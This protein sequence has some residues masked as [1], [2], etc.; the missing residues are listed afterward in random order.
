MS[1]LTTCKHFKFDELWGEFKCLKHCRRL[2]TSKE[3][4]KC[5]DYEK[6][7]GEKK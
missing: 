5:T 3:C 7:G 6:K 1:K 4:L 2:I